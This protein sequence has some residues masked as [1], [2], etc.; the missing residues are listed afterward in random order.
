MRIKEV[1]TCERPREKLSK[2]GPDKLTTAELLAILLRTG[3]KGKNVIEVA[4]TVLATFPA[5]SL[6][7]ARVEDLK[8]IQGVGVVRA[9]EIIACLELGKRLLKDKKSTLIL[10][11][12][13]VWKE[14]KDIVSHKK[15][16]FVIFY[17]DARQQ[18]IKREI[19][20]VGILNASL[21]HPREVFEPAVKATAA[22]VIVAHNH[23]SGDTQP[24]D[25]D[26]ALTKQLAA[27]GSILGIEVLDHVIVG[28]S[29][30]LSF[31][32]QGLL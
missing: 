12:E 19:I 31:R 16:H 26:V 15:E 20:S 8:K 9:L 24:S 5:R 11:P 25:E 22:Q 32:E 14:L 10:S 28:V 6:L 4:R 1:P 2:Y 27:A 17:L 7:E 13:T 18:E 21:V 30:Y 3:T 23:P 29:G